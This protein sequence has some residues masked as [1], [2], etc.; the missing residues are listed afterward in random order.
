MKE[1]Q[2]CLKGLVSLGTIIQ[3]KKKKRKQKKH[4]FLN[5]P[6]PVRYVSL[7]WRRRRGNNAKNNSI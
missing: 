7:E 1:I 5:V 3:S 6:G 4:L 2:R